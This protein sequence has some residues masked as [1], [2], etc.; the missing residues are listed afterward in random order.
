MTFEDSTLGLATLS[1]APAQQSWKDLFNSKIPIVTTTGK[2]GSFFGGQR[3]LYHY[4]SEVKCKNVIPYPAG[5]CEE[6]KYTLWMV[7]L[8]LSSLIV[9]RA[10]R[11]DNRSRRAASR[12]SS[13]GKRS[14][15]HRRLT[16][17]R[18]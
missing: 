5:H 6:D 17:K 1:G 16:P 9:K 2:L 7:A 18:R 14:G 13:R 10:L 12:S 4:A 8:Q 11:D 3:V 15:S